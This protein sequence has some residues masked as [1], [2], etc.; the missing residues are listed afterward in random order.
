ETCLPGF[1]VQRVY[2]GDQ[3]LVAVVITLAR[4]V[5]HR[6]RDPGLL[7]LLDLH[8]RMTL[9]GRHVRP[10]AASRDDGTAE[11]GVDVEHR[12]EAPVHADRKST[13]LNSS[14][15]KISYAVFCL[16]KKNKRRRENDRSRVTYL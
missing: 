16:K 14:H 15:V 6:R 10:E 12:R 2:G 8:Q 1:H 7:E 9:D 5:L 3:V 13:R 4:L 11:G